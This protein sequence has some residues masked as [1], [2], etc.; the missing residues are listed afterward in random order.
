MIDGLNGK[1]MFSFIYL[2]IFNF[3]FNF[4]ENA[5]M[6]AGGQTGRERISSILPTESGVLY[7]VLKSVIH[8]CVCVCDSF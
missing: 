8:L 1:S 7:F 4:R 5:C 2:F 6:R 3:F